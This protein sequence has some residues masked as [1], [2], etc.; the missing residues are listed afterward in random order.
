MNKKEKEYVAS[1]INNFSNSNMVTPDKVN[2]HVV[3]AAYEALHA[4][5]TCS[6]A[7]DI[8]P[9][10]TYSRPGVSYIVKELVGIGKRI[11]ERGEGIYHICRVVISA[12]YR[13]K[14]R[15]ALGGL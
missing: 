9:R 14:I 6:A 4:A 3:A 15:L 12:D 11:K 5:S 10:P 1:V 7:M 13:T 2:D 8:M